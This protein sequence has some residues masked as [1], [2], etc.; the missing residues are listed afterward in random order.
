MRYLILCLLP[1]LVACNRAYGPGPSTMASYDVRGENAPE[2]DTRKILYSAGVDLTVEQPDSAVARLVALAESL[3]GY[4]SQTGSDGAVLRVPAAKFERALVSIGTFGKVTDQ[5][6]TGQDVTDAY[7]D[8]GIRL[9]NAERS[10][11]R[12][13]ELL[14]KAENVGETLLVEKELERLTETIDLLKG[15]RQL[16]DNQEAFATVRVNVQER[17]KLGPLGYVVRGVYGVVKWLFV[18][19]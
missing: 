16:L 2:D 10:R 12:Y 14:A 19:N 13:L 18:R 11:Q 1:L 4:V 15:R 3:N 9:D 8:L 5:R 17:V 7:R 6:V